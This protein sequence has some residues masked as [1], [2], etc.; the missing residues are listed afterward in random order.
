VTGETRLHVFPGLGVAIHQ[1]GVGTGFAVPRMSDPVALAVPR[2]TGC[3]SVALR[4]GFVPSVLGAAIVVVS[5]LLAGCGSDRTVKTDTSS[6]SITTG[7]VTSTGV[8][9]SSPGN[10]K[11]GAP[12]DPLSDCLASKGVAAADGTPSVEPPLRYPPDIAVAA[13]SACRDVYVQLT[14]L[15]PQGDPLA[16][17]D[18]MATFGWVIAQAGFYGEVEDLEQYTA[19]NDTCGAPVEGESSDA[20]YCRFVNAVFDV[21]EHDPSMSIT[22]VPN[23]TSSEDRLEAAVRLYDEALQVAPEALVEDLQTLREGFRQ[24]LE[25]LRNEEPSTSFPDEALERVG[26]HNTRVCGAWVYLGALD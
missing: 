10:T 11:Q 19:A 25:S 15:S 6:S 20:S 22:G 9:A 5:L 12:L 7:A 16:F 8:L 23:S 21:A 1:P 4:N 14:Q 2:S 13:W 18:C 24:S 17:A 26:D 3:R